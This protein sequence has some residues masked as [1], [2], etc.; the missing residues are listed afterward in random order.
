M[1]TDRMT[2]ASLL[3]KG[4]DGDLLRVSRGDMTASP[5]SAVVAVIGAGAM[6]GIVQVLADL[7]EIVGK[8]VIPA[9]NTSSLPVAAI[10]VGLTHST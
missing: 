8:D 7:E 5:K 3:E 2:L 10:A 1:T 9:T 4:A 6:A